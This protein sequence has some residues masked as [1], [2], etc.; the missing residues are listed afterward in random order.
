MRV[1]IF[2]PAG[3]TLARCVGIDGTVRTVETALLGGLDPGAIVL[4]CGDV[5][6]AQ[7]D[8]EWVL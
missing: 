6:L 3:G 4:V 8:A 5:A 7:L 2:H 1:L